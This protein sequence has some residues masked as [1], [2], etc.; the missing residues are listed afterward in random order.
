MCASFKVRRIGHLENQVC[1]S[2]DLVW[3]D[4][5]E[6]ALNTGKPSAYTIIRPSQAPL[7]AFLTFWLKVTKEKELVGFFPVQ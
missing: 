7:N 4:M 3:L 2:G 5:P 1:C 6:S